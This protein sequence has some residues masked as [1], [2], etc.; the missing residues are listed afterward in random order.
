[1]AII[2]TDK[3]GP[4]I[5]QYKNLP[6]DVK[7][8]AQALNKISLADGGTLGAP[9]QKK[10][11]EISGM[12]TEKFL[13][14]VQE[15]QLKHFGWKGADR[16]VFPGG[17]TITKINQILDKN[18]PVNP[19]N[20]KTNLFHFRIADKMP[21][22]TTKFV[23]E[24]IDPS[25]NLDAL[26]IGGIQPLAPKLDFAAERVR[27][28]WQ[29]FAISVE[30]FDKAEFR[31]STTLF[32]RNANG[33]PDG[34]VAQNSLFLRLNKSGTSNMIAMPSGGDFMIADTVAEKRYG[35]GDGIRNVNIEGVLTRVT[36]KK[37]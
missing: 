31:Y 35:L 34:W 11:D 20:S 7:N 4:N 19:G 18:A 3:V 8:I 16:R 30:D 21:A 27:H 28:L 14:G 29:G 24:V 10:L 15:F 12:V 5:G 2:L 36:R 26:Y 13:V 22:R 17:E 6:T 25:N 23:V 1:M 32:P 37:P 33:K 9:P